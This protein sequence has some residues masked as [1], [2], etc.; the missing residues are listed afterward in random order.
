MNKTILLILATP[1]MLAVP[2]LASDRSGDDGRER[3]EYRG[4]DHETRET[5]AAGEA[6]SKLEADGYHVV[7]VERE[8]GRLE[9]KA[10]REGRLYEIDIDAADGRI[11]RMRED[12]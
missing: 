9:V 7:K 5:P 11:I 3:L 1:L 2:A 12:D 10:V 8:H 4:G 6:L